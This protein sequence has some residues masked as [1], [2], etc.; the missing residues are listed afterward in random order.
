MS[1][2]NGKKVSEL[3]VIDLKEQLTKRKL[4][5]KGKKQDLVA[6][7]L[8]ALE[9]EQASTKQT[10]TNNEED[11]D[12]EGEEQSNETKQEAKNKPA[13]GNE[14]QKTTP[15]KKESNETAKKLPEATT[16]SSNGTDHKEV[17]LPP[18]TATILE[19]DKKNQEQ[20]D[21]EYLTRFQKKRK[22]NGELRSLV[23]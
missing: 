1:L 5:A 8:E 14:G 20:S 13:T 22:N 6:R 11:V 3:L 9:K 15:T 18:A 17:T 23:P 21:S 10:D 4:D 19:S 16:S 7:L 12:V 2:I